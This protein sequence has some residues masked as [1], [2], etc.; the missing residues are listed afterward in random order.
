[1]LGNLGER[2]SV[3]DLMAGHHS[4]LREFY[5]SERPQEGVASTRTLEVF[6]WLHTPARH[7]FLDTHGCVHTPK[8]TQER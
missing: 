4:L 5:T 1:M 7:M 8:H 3:L 2:D 6:L